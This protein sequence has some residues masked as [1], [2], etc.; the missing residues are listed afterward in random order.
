MIIDHHRIEGFIN[1][2]TRCFGAPPA[3]ITVR[4]GE[5]EMQYDNHNR[6][7]L[8]REEKTGADDRDYSGQLNVDG[9]EY[10]LSGWVKT[11]KKGQKFLS[12][13]VKPKTPA[14]AQEDTD[15]EIPF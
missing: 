4:H 11:S 1:E 9:V 3:S 6:G 8:F 15:D 2:A 7:A 5:T 12:L 14:R 13:S 10:W